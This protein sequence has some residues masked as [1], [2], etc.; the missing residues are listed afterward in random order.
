MEQNLRKVKISDE[1]IV[2]R[3]IRSNDP[4][5]ESFAEVMRQ[6][7][8]ES[9]EKICALQCRLYIEGGW[10]LRQIGKALGNS[11]EW[12]RTEIVACSDNDHDHSD[13]KSVV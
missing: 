5:P 2:N 10:S 9:K 11:G 12:A 3:Y 13:R 7:R 1:R 6:A 4:I 8:A